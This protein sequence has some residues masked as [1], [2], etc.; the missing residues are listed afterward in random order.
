MKCLEGFRFYDLIGW[1]IYECILEIRKDSRYICFINQNKS[2]RVKICENEFIND[3]MKAGVFNWER[4]YT[5]SM[6]LFPNC[7]WSISIDIDGQNFHSRGENAIP[8][9]WLNMIN[10]FRKWKI[11]II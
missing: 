1:D 7:T 11:D 5:S 4:Y 9:D 8:N 10:V 3:L 2:G 6:E